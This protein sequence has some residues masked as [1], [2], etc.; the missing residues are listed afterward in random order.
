MLHPET[1]EEIYEDHYGPLKDFRT[2]TKEY[3]KSLEAE[4]EDRGKYSRVYL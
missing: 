2:L 3:L 4:L 1:D